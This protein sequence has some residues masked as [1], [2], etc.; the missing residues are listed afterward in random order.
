MQTPGI[1]SIENKHST[2]ATEVLEIVQTIYLLVAIAWVL[3]R[4]AKSSS[5]LSS[6]QEKLTGKL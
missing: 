3:S 5:L 6:Y 1:L 2:L 4:Y